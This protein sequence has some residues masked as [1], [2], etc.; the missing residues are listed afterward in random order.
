MTSG[1]PQ[2]PSPQHP[3]PAPTG[4]TPSPQHPT[5]TPAGPAPAPAGATATPHHRRT[6]VIEV[7]DAA[8][9]LVEVAGRLRDERPWAT[10]ALDLPVVHDLGLTVTVSL[11]DF[12]VQEVHV[13]FRTYPHAECVDIAAAHQALVGLT[14]GRGW[15]A[16]VRE[17]LGGPAGCTHLRELARSMAPTLLQAAFS[18]RLRQAGRDAPEYREAREMLPLIADTCHVWAVGGVAEQKLERGWR[19]GEMLTPI[20]ALA[21]LDEMRA[22]M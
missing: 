3:T 15:N 2:L 10:D 21:E 11:A 13:D 9:G 16:A 17:R 20:P 7:G 6:V 12:V 19:P 1:D 22:D 5:P 14:L 8:G 4:P 18:A